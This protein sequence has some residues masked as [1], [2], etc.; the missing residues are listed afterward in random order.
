MP[1]LKFIVGWNGGRTGTEV[2]IYYR[3]FI[4]ILLNTGSYR[5][6]ITSGNVTPLH[7]A[8]AFPLVTSNNM[9]HT[10]PHTPQYFRGVYFSVHIF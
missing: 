1:E 7:L 6:D 2:I 4:S 3:A 10:Y 8:L 5:S 9:W